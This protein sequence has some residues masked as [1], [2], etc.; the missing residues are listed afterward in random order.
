MS[1]R[2]TI[3]L[4]S[5]ALP[6]NLLAL[7]MCILFKDNEAVVKEAAAAAQ[8]A[9]HAQ[10]KSAAMLE[11]CD[12]ALIRLKHDHQVSLKDSENNRIVELRNFD[13][14]GKIG[15]CR[16]VWSKTHKGLAGNNLKRCLHCLR[17][18]RICSIC[19]YCVKIMRL[20]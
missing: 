12:T 2:G 5:E 9:E 3:W 19:A 16:T 17:I 18:L 6:T 7:Y 10:R 11:A 13:V 8:H 15:K 4:D 14:S 1:C 20:L